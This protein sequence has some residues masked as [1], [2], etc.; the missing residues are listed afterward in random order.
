[1]IA[2]TDLGARALALAAPLG[3]RGFWMGAIA[4]MAT[5]TLGI[6]AYFLFV[7]G[8]QIVHARLAV[9]SPASSAA[10]R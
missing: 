2:L 5:A 1:V 6:I 8:R 7:S 10:S 9:R 4:G 3:A